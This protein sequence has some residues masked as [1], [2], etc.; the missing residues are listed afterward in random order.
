MGFL[1][2]TRVVRQWLFNSL[3]LTS[4]RTHCHVASL[5]KTKRSQ[6]HRKYWTL[7]VKPDGSTVHFRYKEPRRIITLP[8]D[9][10]M[11]SEKERLERI[12]ERNPTK[13]SHDDI[14]EE[15]FNFNEYAYLWKKK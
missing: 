12:A 11:L 15:V 13:L 5:G 4:G 1:L 10:S 9:L 14:V 3:I 2:S 7:L 6:Y 8:I